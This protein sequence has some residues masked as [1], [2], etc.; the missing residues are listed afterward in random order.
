MDASDNTMLLDTGCG[1]DNCSVIYALEGYQ[2]IGV[3]K[4]V[5]AFKVSVRFQSWQ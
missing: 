3:D 1:L 4:V 5:D 2:V